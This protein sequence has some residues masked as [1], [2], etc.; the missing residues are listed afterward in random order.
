MLIWPIWVCLGGRYFAAK[1]FILRYWI[2][3][4][5]FGF[6]RPNR[7]LSTGYTEFPLEKFSRA[8]CLPDIRNAGT[9]AAD[10]AMG[11]AD[12]FIGPAYLDF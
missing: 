8:L 6:S 4:D 10:K 5:F 3:L 7:E 1:T 11:K 2:S 9:A 12:L